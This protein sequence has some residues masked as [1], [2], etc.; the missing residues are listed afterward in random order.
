[1]VGFKS[2][3]SCVASTEIHNLADIIQDTLTKREQD[4]SLPHSFASTKQESILEMLNFL[5]AHNVLD[6]DGLHDAVMTMHRKLNAVRDDLKRVEPKLKELTE[7]N[8]LTSSHQKEYYMTQNENEKVADSI[9]SC[10]EKRIKGT[11]YIVTTSFNGDENRSVRSSLMHLISRENI[12]DIDSQSIT[13]NY[14][15]H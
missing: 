10:V 9:I 7:H 5:Q 15:S 8:L 11:T 6:L 12:T 1:L 13:K 14:S 4:N 2:R 3:G